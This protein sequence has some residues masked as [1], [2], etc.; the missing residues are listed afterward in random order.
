MPT[1]QEQAD[2]PHSTLF[3]AELKK[4]KK[5]LVILR[6]GNALAR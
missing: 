2:L 6:E 1:E 3:T 5:N 4:N